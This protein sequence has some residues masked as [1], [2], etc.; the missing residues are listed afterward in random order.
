[1]HKILLLIKNVIKSWLLYRNASNFF[2]KFIREIFFPINTKKYDVK[3]LY[4]RYKGPFPVLSRPSRSQMEIKVGT[5]ANGSLRKEIRHASD[6]KVGHLREDATI[7][8]RPKRGRPAKS[9]AN[10]EPNSK[11]EDISTNIDE[12]PPFHGFGSQARIDF[13]KPPPGFIAGNS[14][15]VPTHPEP[16]QVTGPPPFS[17]F[18]QRGAWQASP[19]DLLAINNSIAGVSH[20]SRTSLK[21]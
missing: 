14:N 4:S 12:D 5:N 9:P 18:M 19:E 1:M 11:P 21:G 10:I 17:G 15:P 16:T 3:S 13:S 20:G 7:A 2:M 8:E 6:L